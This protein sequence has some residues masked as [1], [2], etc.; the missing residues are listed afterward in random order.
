[1][2][3]NAVKLYNDQR[4]D[5]FFYLFIYFLQII[6]FGKRVGSILSCI[7]TQGHELFLFSEVYSKA[8]FRMEK[9]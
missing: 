9:L 2:Q 4:N 8:P 1:M 3:Q 5:K 7:G 6:I